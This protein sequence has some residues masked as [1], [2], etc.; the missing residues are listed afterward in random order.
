MSRGAQPT[1]LRW[2]RL[3]DA[4]ETLKRHDLIA[5]KDG[6]LRI[7]VE[8]FRRWVVQRLNILPESINAS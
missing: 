1:P 2:E 7:I 6:R 3:N 5:E 8:L 4:L